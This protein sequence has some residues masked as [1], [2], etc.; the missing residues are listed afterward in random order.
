MCKVQA[1]GPR[2]VV[3]WFQLSPKGFAD[4]LAGAHNT[5]KVITHGCQRKP[6]IAIDSVL[7]SAAR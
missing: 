4:M 5:N 1:A 6:E 7:H 2:L 3:V